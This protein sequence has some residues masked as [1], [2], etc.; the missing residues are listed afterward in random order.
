MAIDRLSKDTIKLDSANL[1]SETLH[2][3]SVEE[4]SCL[5]S[6]PTFKY[7][8]L[9]QARSFAQKPETFSLEHEDIRAK[10][11]ISQAKMFANENRFM[12]NPSETMQTIHSENPGKSAGEAS[13]LLQY[14]PIKEGTPQYEP[15][16]TNL[17][18]N[19]IP[20]NKREFLK[21]ESMYQVKE[22]T[23]PAKKPE[24]KA[25]SKPESK[26][27]TARQKRKQMIEA[28]SNPIGPQV[29]KRSKSRN[30][31]PSSQNSRITSVRVARSTSVTTRSQLNT[32]KRPKARS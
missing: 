29:P 21:F 12:F 17:V 1:P 30:K 5:P 6:E 19:V 3:R 20:L 28:Y 26:P 18:P 7:N 9:R 13:P 8:D 25:D 27:Q 23:L 4:S 2:P 16:L 10:T 14:S 31:R 11:Q 24:V 32:S 22:N 15:V